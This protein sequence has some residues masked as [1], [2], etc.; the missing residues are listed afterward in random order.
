M[1]DCFLTTHKP[2]SKDRKY[3]EKL[4]VLSLRNNGFR[5]IMIRKKMLERYWEAERLATSDIYIVC[6]NDIVLP[7]TD[8]LQ[9]LV[10]TMRKYPELSQLGLAWKQNMDSEANSPWRIGTIG[11]DVWEFFACGGCMAIRKG[12]IKDIGIQMEF[13]NYGDDRVLGQTARF[14]GYKVGIA[15][16]LYMYHLGNENTTFKQEN[17][18]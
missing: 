14:L 7:T 10:E 16:K 6:D 9:K 15:H 11:D 3:L 13:R 1:I 5:P 2:L 8:T 18:T 12:T 17:T 4:T